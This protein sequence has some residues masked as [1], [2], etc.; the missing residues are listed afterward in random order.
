MKNNK[1][2]YLIC[3]LVLILFVFASALGPGLILAG[4]DY[5]RMERPFLKQNGSLDLANLNYAYGKPMREKLDDFAQGLAAGK[6]YHTAFTEYEINQEVQDLKQH[7]IQSEEGPLLLLQIFGRVSLSD[8]SDVEIK[9]CKKYV[10]YEEEFTN[11]AAFIAWYLQMEINQEID[12]RVLMDIDS[13]TIYY[14][15]ANNINRMAVIRNLEYATVDYYELCY[16]SYEYYESDYEEHSVKS[17][18]REGDFDT[19]LWPLLYERSTLDFEIKELYEMDMIVCE[20][21]GIRQIGEL[22][23]ELM[24]E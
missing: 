19:V 21:I 1:R 13:D 6:Q 16:Y 5:Y 12:L 4:Q 3:W 2:T 7:F 15:A 24:Q 18:I 11:G 22:I 14:A 10:I 17:T 8:A 23:P 9:A 20:K